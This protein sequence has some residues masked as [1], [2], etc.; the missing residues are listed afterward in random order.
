[1]VEIR[2]WLAEAT[3]HLDVDAFF[4]ALEALEN[5]DLKDKP[6]I[7]GGRPDELGVAATPSYAARKRGSDHRV[8]LAPADPGT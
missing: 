3:V 1:M 7:V 6:V 4:A 8:G 2:I 5:L